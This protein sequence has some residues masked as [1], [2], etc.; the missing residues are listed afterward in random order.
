MPTA[1]QL[2]RAADNAVFPLPVATSSTFCPARKPAASHISSPG[3]TVCQPIIAKSPSAQVRCCCALTAPRSVIAILLEILSVQSIDA[4]SV[5]MEQH[6]LLYRRPLSDCRAESSEDRLKTSAQAIH[7]IVAREHAALDAEDSD[8]IAN[9][10]SVR[11][12]CPRI[13]RLPQARDLDENV[14][15]LREEV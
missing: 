12:Y 15:V 4:H 9:D 3:N 6:A 1:S 13:A 8:G 11:C 7:G 10:W 2:R 5:V 14:G